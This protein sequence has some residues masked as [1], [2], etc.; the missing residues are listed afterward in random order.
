MLYCCQKYPLICTNS[1]LENI[2]QTNALLAFVCL[3]F[4]KNYRAKFLGKFSFFL[5]C[6]NI[7]DL[8]LKLF[9]FNRSKRAE[10]HR[11]ARSVANCWDELQV[12]KIHKN[13]SLIL[14]MKL[15][16]IQTTSQKRGSLMLLTMLHF[17]SCLSSLTL[18]I[19]ESWRVRYALIRC[20]AILQRPA[21][22]GRIVQPV[23][24]SG[25]M[26]LHH[27]QG[28]WKMCGL[29]KQSWTLHPLSHSFS[30]L[31]KLIPQ[32]SAELYP[33]SGHISWHLEHTTL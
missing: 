20:F 30:P 27:L 23:H 9:I 22:D 14:W 13:S 21:N 17:A 25:Q 6:K 24:L 29:A 16:A 4:A 7:C 32:A 26:A 2:S 19:G 28:I 11:E 3:I 18:L 10:C 12:R 33:T 5:N 31:S 8:F 1:H 15:I